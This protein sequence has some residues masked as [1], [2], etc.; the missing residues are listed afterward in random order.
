MQ[1]RWHG[2]TTYR[3]QLLREMLA[4]T[5]ILLSLAASLLLLSPPPHS[6]QIRWYDARTEPFLPSSPPSSLR[7]RTPTQ[8]SRQ[9]EKTGMW[10]CMSYT[11]LICR[12]MGNVLFS[13]SRRGDRFKSWSEI[14]FS[15]FSL[16]PL[17][18]EKQGVFTLP[19]YFTATPP[20]PPPPHSASPLSDKRGEPLISPPH[21]PSLSL[22]T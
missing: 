19:T 20:P 7:R 5:V 4:Q 15:F 1:S 10:P 22:V 3:R 2:N 18:T 11:R 16:F 14:T 12:L 9:C 13:R 8:S 21:T 17:L 6:P